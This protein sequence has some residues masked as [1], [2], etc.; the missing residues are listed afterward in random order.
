MGEGSHRILIVD[1]DPDTLITL[2]HVLED[3][4]V[5]TTVTWDEAE[6]RQ[7]VRSKPFDLILVGDHPPELTAETLLREFRSRDTV[8]PCLILRGFDL[9]RNTD[10]SWRGAIGTIPKWDPLVVL[11]E[12][13]KHLH[14]GVVQVSF[15]AG[16]LTEARLRQMAS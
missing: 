5:D 1:T 9:D 12:V 15:A 6:A 16:G 10:R 11:E 7:L 13:Q 8:Y 14:A 3:A 4:G 2:Q